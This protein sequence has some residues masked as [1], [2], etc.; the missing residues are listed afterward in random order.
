[1]TSL[2]VGMIECTDILAFCDRYEPYRMPLDIDILCQRYN[3]KVLKSI[4]AV[5]LDMGLSDETVRT[6]ENCALDAIAHFLD[7]EAAG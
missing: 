5:A 4:C 3:G 7:L 2:G 6:I 1:M